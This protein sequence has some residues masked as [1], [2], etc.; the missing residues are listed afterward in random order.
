MINSM[1]QMALA[2][3]FLI[4]V[5][6]VPAFTWA[7]P[8]VAAE[9]GVD[10]SK[11][12]QAETARASLPEL[13]AKYDPSPL[14]RAVADAVRPAVVEVR[15]QK[16]LEARDMAA[17]DMDDFFRRFFGEE[18]PEGR[19]PRQLPQ[20]P[21]APSTPRKRE[22]FSRGLGSGVIVEASKGLILTNHHVVA[23]ADEVEVVLADGRKLGTEWVRSDPKT[24]LAVLKVKPDKLTSAPLGDSDAMDVGDVVLA[25]GSPEGLPQTVTMGI[26]SAKG[27]NTSD[28]NAYQSFLQTDA[29]INHGN[30]GGPL[31]NLHGEVI[32]I[33]AAI[34]SRT[35]VNEGIG[36]AIPSSMAKHIMTEL[37]EKGK[38]VRGYLGVVIQNATE[39]L[40]KSFNLPG[41]DG[42]LV[43]QVS[44]DSP[45]AK[46]GLKSGDF[47][48]AIDGKPAK[49]VNTVRNAVAMIKPGATVPVDVIR[50]GKKTT[51][52]VTIQEQPKDMGV[53]GEGEEG[54][55]EAA[56]P[57][58]LKRF[59]LEVTTL[60]DELAQRYGFKS[61]TRGALV[62]S[63]APASDAAK[64][65]LAEGMVIVQAQDKAVATADDLKSALNAPD[66]AN[67]VRLKV[68]D[69]RGSQ[70]FVFIAPA[71]ESKS[72]GGD[73]PAE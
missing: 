27:R 50:G 48:V 44:P 71:R 18:S 4:S 12:S 19:L 47:I 21:N 65:G 59:G 55:P 35:G 25:I 73:K 46:A 54:T 32:G 13:A 58:S 64:E 6:A 57:Q 61:G 10:A 51:L 22:F 2:W 5:I 42:A 33:N 49:N 34:V 28:P 11:K 26:I 23:G 69:R 70:L 30:S 56:E 24:D 37:V 67:G 63:V 7:G 52:P 72:D 17:P 68:M 15:V 16:K 29:A 31:V 38:V 36:L 43:S 9:P 62:T 14:F 20:R 39:G 53:A 8:A 45:A 41:T 66:A 3:A 1:K 40:A 60:T